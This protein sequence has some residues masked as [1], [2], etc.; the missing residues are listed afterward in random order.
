MYS[1]NSRVFKGFQDAYEPC[2][3][4]AHTSNK[5]SLH[6]PSRAP[7]KIGV[8]I[9][10]IDLFSTTSV[11]KKISNQKLSALLID[12]IVCLT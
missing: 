2:H 11:T 12:W 4:D 1:Q 6:F 3:V 7:I 9:G 10:I 5:F 8:P